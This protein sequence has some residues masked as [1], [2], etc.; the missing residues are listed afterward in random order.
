MLAGR[1]TGTSQGFGLITGGA[2]AIGT[3]ICRRLIAAG[4]PVGIADLDAAA[5]RATAAALSGAG[6]HVAWAGCDV[7]SAGSV[8]DAH[9]KLR[10]ELGP[11]GLLVNNAGVLGPTATL[12]EL[13]EADWQRV[14]AV[15]LTG[16]W[17]ASRAVIPDM[18]ELGSGR[19][20][21][22]CSGSSLIGTPGYG[23]YAASKAALLSLTKT[24]AL[25]LAATGVRVTAVCPGNVDTPMLGVIE[26]ALAAAGD[27][28]PRETLTRY[29][30]LPRLATPDDVAGVVAFLASADAD[31]LTGSPIL[32]DGGALA[33][34][35]P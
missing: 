12:E 30:A 22:V 34:R 5:A 9:A 18:R 7:T 17:L 21:N 27:P 15:N 31:F 11:V 29:H 1:Q 24:L 13:P 19:I 3:A 8:A 23:A 2:G 26:N 33:G 32:V 4:W 16:A 20:V 10:A 14:L 28:A 25:E 35:A 6:A